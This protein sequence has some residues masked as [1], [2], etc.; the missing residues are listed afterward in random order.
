VEAL[1][2]Q[3]AG[4]ELKVP[5]RRAAENIIPQLKERHFIHKVPPS[6]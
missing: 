1:F 3:F 5:G 2:Q 4:T 6:E